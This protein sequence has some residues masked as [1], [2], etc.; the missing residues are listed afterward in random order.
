MNWKNVE[1]ECLKLGIKYLEFYFKT[2]VLEIED[3]NT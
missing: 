3:M 1:Y 2:Y